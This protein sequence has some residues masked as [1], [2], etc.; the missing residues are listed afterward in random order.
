MR[1]PNAGGRDWLCCCVRPEND[2]VLVYGWKLTCF[3]WGWPNW[4]S[5][6]LRAENDLV[7]CRHWNLLGFLWVIEIN[8]MSVQEMKTDLISVKGSE[9]NWFLCGGRK[10]L[11]FSFWIEIVFV[12]GHLNHTL[13]D[14]RW[15]YLLLIG[16]YHNMRP[17]GPANGVDTLYWGLLVKANRFRSP[18]SQKCWPA[19][20][21]SPSSWRPITRDDIYWSYIPRHIL[22]TNTLPYFGKEAYY[23]WW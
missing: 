22:S 15:A 9:L 10:W 2:S 20:R 12:S 23:V 16:S 3:L 8:L 7:L 11:G 17:I 21:L 4:L 1:K 13:D 6:C 18:A 5:F 19:N 14:R